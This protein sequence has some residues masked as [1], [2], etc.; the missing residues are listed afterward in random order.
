MANFT[1][2]YAGGRC[3]I[4]LDGREGDEISPEMASAWGQLTASTALSAIAERL[5]DIAA[6]LEDIHREIELRKVEE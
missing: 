5:A 6:S 2:S 1:V 3:H 4:Y